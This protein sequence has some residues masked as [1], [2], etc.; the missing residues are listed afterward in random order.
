MLVQQHCFQ[1]LFEFI[2]PVNV[3]LYFWHTLAI[4]GCKDFIVIQFIYLSK[5]NC[6]FL[7]SG[8]Q[9]N[10]ESFGGWGAARPPS[11]KGENNAMN[12]RGTMGQLSSNW[13]PFVN[14]LRKI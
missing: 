5:L 8:C 1:S 6:L 12:L 13:G 14:Y 11:K 9:D 7:H 4:A 2:T 3:Q 10:E